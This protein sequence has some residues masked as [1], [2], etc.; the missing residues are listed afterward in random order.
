ME[1]FI[2]SRVGGLL[3]EKMSVPI[4]VL[5][6]VAC[7]DWSTPAG[8]QTPGRPAAD[9]ARAVQQRYDTVHDFSAEFTHTYEGGALHK[10]VTERGTVEIK[11]PGRMRWEY[12]DPEKKLFVA[13]GSEIYSYIPADRQVIVSPMPT[14]DQ[15]TTATLFLTGKGNITRDFTVSYASVPDAPPET[16]ALKLLPRLPERDYDALTLAVDAKSLQIRMLVAVDRQ[17]GKSTFTFSGIKENTGLAD[18]IFTFKIP[19]GTDVVRTGT[20]T[21]RP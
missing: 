10:K 19:R 4:A 21:E 11:K 5:A 7:A 17:G 12:T 14:N 9:L 13:D 20:G 8:A 2:F 16:V 15:A 18:K 6:L 3:R 1:P